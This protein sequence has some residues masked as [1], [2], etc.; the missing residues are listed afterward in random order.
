MTH[1]IACIHAT[2]L[3]IGP[4]VQAFSQWVPEWKRLDIIEE[5]LFSLQGEG[6]EAVSIFIETLKRAE[7][8]NPGAILTTC[9]LYTRY[10]QSVRSLIK[11]PVLGIDEPMIEKAVEMGGKL[12][13]VG[14]LASAIEGT[15][16]LIKKGAE[17]KGQWVDIS[18]R[19]LVDPNLCST[20]AGMK[21]LAERLRSLRHEVDGV[22]VVQASLSNVAELLS[23]EENERILTSPRLAIFRLQQIL[24]ERKAAC[25]S[26]ERV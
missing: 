6:E 17:A 23:D 8:E 19:L 15:A 9:S 3:A 7:A 5:R 24:E 20:P 14:F 18:T 22:V 21:D 25:D 11:R 4:V 12:A 16:S 26:V 10:L 1:L 2:P 13:L